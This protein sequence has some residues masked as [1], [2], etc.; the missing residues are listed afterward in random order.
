MLQ[1][2]YPGTAVIVYKCEHLNNILL[3]LK[4]E[5]GPEQ[6]GSV[7]WAMSCK[8]KRR[9]L[10]SW[11]HAWVEGSVPGQGVYER[12]PIDVSVSHQCFSLSLSP[13][14]PISLKNK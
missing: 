10:D 8:A 7:T 11:S 13:S 9:W 1:L 14:L 12:Q 5:Y 3:C 4:Q 2:S 6:C